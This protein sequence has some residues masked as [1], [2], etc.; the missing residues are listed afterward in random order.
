[1]RTT[2]TLAIVLCIVYVVLSGLY[3]FRVG[4]VIYQAKASNT[5]IALASGM[6]GREETE[7]YAVNRLRVPRFITESPAFWLAL[8]LSE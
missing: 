6:V 3:G 8:R 4:R 7:R 1:M 5:Y 2:I